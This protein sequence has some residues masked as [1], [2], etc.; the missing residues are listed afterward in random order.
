M[1]LNKNFKV[2]IGLVGGSVVKSFS[3]AGWETLSLVL[4]S[5]QKVVG[6]SQIGCPWVAA[7]PRTPCLAPACCIEL[8]LR[9]GLWKDY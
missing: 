4:L 9:P 2:A 6:I 1:G 3:A 7:F 8:K 5:M